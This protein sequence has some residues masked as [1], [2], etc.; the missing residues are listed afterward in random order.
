MVIGI[1]L[2]TTFSAAAY[3]DENGT[4]QMIS[5]SS[6]DRLLPSVVM[7]EEDGSVVVGDD[8]KENL[9]LMSESIVST[10]KDH[11]GT[12]RKMTLSSGNTYSPEQISAFIL[13]K[14]QREA[15]TFLNQPIT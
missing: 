7:E 12:E 4:P 9:V 6:G 1:D 10:V 13:K 3:M 11:M 2:G 15:S 14:I 5:L 8:A